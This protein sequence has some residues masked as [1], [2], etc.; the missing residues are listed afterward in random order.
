MDSCNGLS[1]PSGQGILANLGVAVQGLRQRSREFAS[2]TDTPVA[3][4][5]QTVETV[6]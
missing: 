4:L 5:P 3:V 1:A 6:S 2:M